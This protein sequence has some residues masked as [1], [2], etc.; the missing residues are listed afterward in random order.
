MIFLILQVFYKLNL[1][2]C[3]Y[4]KTSFRLT[5]LRRILKV[6]NEGR[7][8]NH[9]YFIIYIAFCPSASNV[10]EDGRRGFW[11]LPA[12]TPCLAGNSSVPPCKM[13]TVPRCPRFYA[14][15]NSRYIS[16]Q[17]LS[18]WFFHPA[19]YR[20]IHHPCAETQPL[21]FFKTLV[22]TGKKHK[23]AQ[24]VHCF[25]YYYSFPR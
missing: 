16:R 8:N 5:I 17:H 24:R 25:S 10:F 23:S 18:L 11:A 1:I 20:S 6:R 9:A 7:I 2:I 19:F 12:C 14:L 4:V 21:T 22:F 13:I 3:C 15:C